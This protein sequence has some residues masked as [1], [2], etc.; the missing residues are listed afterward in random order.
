MTCENI[1]MQTRCPE[2][3]KQH[4]WVVDQSAKP[5]EGFNPNPTASKRCGCKCHDPM[6][7]TYM[8]G[9]DCCPRESPSTTKAREI[10]FKYGLDIR[11][12]LMNEIAAA[13]DEHGKAEYKRG[14]EAEQTAICDWL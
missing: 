3:Q 9:C 1:S 7:K 10:C 11:G 6:Y 8:N 2:C 14:L 12:D 4:V 13:L 5:Y